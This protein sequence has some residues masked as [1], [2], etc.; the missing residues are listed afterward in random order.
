MISKILLKFGYTRQILLAEA[1]NNANNQT[2]KLDSVTRDLI[3][4]RNEYKKLSKELKEPEK[5]LNK[6]KL[7]NFAKKV[8]RIQKCDCCGTVD[9]P[10]Q[11]H[12]L[13]SKHK[14]PSLA[15]EVAN[16]IALCPEC[17]TGYHTKYPHIEDCSPYTYYE[18]RTDERNKIRLQKAEIEI[19]E[20]KERGL[21]VAIKAKL[22]DLLK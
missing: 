7:Q 14:H 10:F 15:Y 5:C 13:W 12:H 2:K 4:L 3:K 1:V 21:S 11:A 17:H 6:N 22:I 8:K 19:R 9:G 20:L 16:G 18:Y